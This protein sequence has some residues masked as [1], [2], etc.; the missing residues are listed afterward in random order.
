M[1][2]RIILTLMVA[3]IL[4][5]LL[6]ACSGQ[7]QTTEV[8]PQ[9]DGALLEKLSEINEGNA[10]LQ[11]EMAEVSKEN[12]ALQAEMTEVSKENAALQAGLNE[13]KDK[14]HG[15]AT[16][17][18]RIADPTPV[19]RAI[20]TGPGIC[21]RSPAVQSVILDVLNSPYCQ[22]ITDGELFRIMGLPELRV[23][24]LKSGDLQGLVNLPEL[25][26]Y[27]VINIEKGAFEG[28]DNLENMSL[29]V[30]S[31]GQIEPG[32]FVGL[33]SLEEL[34]IAS[35]LPFPYKHSLGPVSLPVI[36]SLPS[37]RRLAVTGNIA[38][39]LM[40]QGA[41]ESFFSNLPSLISLSIGI[42]YEYDANK[43]PVALPVNNAFFDG[44]ASLQEL[45]LRGSG[46]YE[47]TLA[48][49]AFD[50]TPRLREVLISEG[51]LKVHK[52][53][54]Q[55]L[56]ELEVLRMPQKQTQDSYEEH[57]IILSEESPLFTLVMYGQGQGQTQGFRL[58]GE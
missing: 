43:E 30:H 14:D 2:R 21:G 15:E 18:P 27:A 47:I 8:P 55:H 35:N 26:V 41:S 42:K 12:A 56:D 52:N 36:D 3:C 54:F 53:T 49:D 7:G 48:P 51:R 40:L 44:L 10:A 9:S 29:T 20:P 31:Q 5:L 46:L 34:I 57:R 16:Q 50:S 1:K 25:N 19:S 39:Q 33:P 6:M 24:T 32:A 13:L 28:L 23:T 4:S 37:L 45:H 38:T 58:L 11:A 22:F 17:Q